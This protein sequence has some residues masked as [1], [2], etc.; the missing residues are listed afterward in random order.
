M[1]IPVQTCL[2]C[3]M[4][5]GAGRT[6]ATVHLHLHEICPDQRWVSL[7]CHQYANIMMSDFEGDALTHQ[8]TKEHAWCVQ[9]TAAT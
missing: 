5:H 7:L 9:M 6:T 3:T 8:A 2:E 4:D 1:R